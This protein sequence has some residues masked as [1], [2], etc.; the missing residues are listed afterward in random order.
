MAITVPTLVINYT[1]RYSGCHRIFFKTS[2]AEYCYYQDDSPST[3]GTQKTVEI[4]LTDYLDCLVDIPIEIACESITV[5]G[6]IQP[7]CTDINS[8]QNRVLFN[9]PFTSTECNSYRIECLDPFGCGTFTVPDC[10]G[11]NDG[12]EYELRYG[13]PFSEGIY[14]C[15]GG[16]G[17][18]APGY[19]VQGPGGTP[20]CCI[21]KSYNIIVSSDIDIYYT[22]CNQTIDVVTVQTGALGVTVCSIPESIWPVNK[23]DNDFIVSITEVGDCIATE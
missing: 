19:N 18:V 15:S 7:C 12:T 23:T 3:I 5:T 17:P 10:N 16:D 14:V 9:T 1:P 22:S 21:C 4:F 2:Q 20:S 11:E 6:Y 8:N 13:L